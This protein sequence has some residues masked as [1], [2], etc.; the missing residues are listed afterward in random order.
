MDNT[1]TLDCHFETIAWGLLFILWGITILFDFVPVGIGI[2]GTG[3]IL[4]GLN[5][6]RALNGVPTRGGTTTLGILALVW[7]GLDLARSILPLPFELTLFAIFAILLI[8]QGVIVL[9]RELR[10]IRKEGFGNPV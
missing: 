5:A 6:A 9:A 2:V 8:M 3:V 4:L 7:G 10:R 1:R